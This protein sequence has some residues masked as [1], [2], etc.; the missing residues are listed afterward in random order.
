MLTKNKEPVLDP[1]KTVEATCEIGPVKIH[2]KGYYH[3]Q[4][5]DAFLDNLAKKSLDLYVEV[6][7]HKPG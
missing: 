3:D 1:P 5:L 7:K 4:S 6:L 2:I